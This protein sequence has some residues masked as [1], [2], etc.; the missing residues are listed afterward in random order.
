MQADGTT[1][2]IHSGAVMAGHKFSY[3]IFSS[4]PIRIVL[5]I[6]LISAIAYN[7]STLAL[8]FLPDLQRSSQNEAVQ[9]TIDTPSPRQ[10]VM[11]VGNITRSNLFGEYADNSP[12][13]SAPVVTKLNLKLRGVFAVDDPENGIAIIFSPDKGEKYFVAGQ[14]VF[15]QATLKEIYQDYVILFRNGRYETLRLPEKMLASKETIAVKRSTNADRAKRHVEFMRE[16][17]KD[18]HKMTLARMRNPWQY[19]YFEPALVNGKIMGLKLSAEEEKG[20]LAKHGL[21]LNDVITS[22]N[23]NK[24]DGGAG[25][26]KALNVITESDNLE[27]VINRNGQTL[28]ISVKNIQEHQQGID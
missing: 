7:L 2:M 27:L 12:T 15:G 5:N 21:Q 6:M 13:R 18:I 14:Q 10:P 19:L 9:P 17:M 8:M 23:G 4:E 24:L 11:D 26:A 16:K 3:N 22:I 25:V 20:F 28:T 1:L